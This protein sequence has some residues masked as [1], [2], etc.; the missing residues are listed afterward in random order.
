MHNTD[1]KSTTLFSQTTLTYG[2]IGVL[3]RVI[4]AA[5][6]LCNHAGV[7]L[8]I[9]TPAEF[10]GVN[11]AN[12]KS[13]KPIVRLFDHRFNDLNTSNSLFIVGRD[14]SGDVVACQA[15]R[16]FDLTGTTF[17][18]EFA[19]KRIYYSDPES[20]SEPGEHYKVT[21]LAAHGTTGRIVFSGGAWYR[22]DF[23]GKGLVGWLPRLARAYARSVW[24]ARVTVTGMT[25]QNVG[26][27][28][29]PRNGYRNME[30]GIECT[31][32]DYGHMELAYLWMKE[33]ETIEDL[34]QFLSSLP[35]F[36]GVAAV[37]TEKGRYVVR[38]NAGQ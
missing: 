20:M 28:V 4:L 16:L 8:S 22:H 24:D 35:D 15:A 9:V 26:K 30:W 32:S 19:S 2:P 29:F 34:Q 38:S 1:N 13:W 10:L 17:A 37:G 6:Q 27:G 31:N 7:R 36:E 23:R 5:E 18:E 33:K 25:V 14:A 11:Q 12:N 21:S 3:G